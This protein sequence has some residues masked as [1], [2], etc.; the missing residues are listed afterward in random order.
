MSHA[1]TESRALVE[2]LE[3]IAPQGF[4]GRASETPIGAEEVQCAVE[5]VRDTLVA[6]AEAS[7]ATL[8]ERYA[9]LLAAA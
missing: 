3:H 9:A 7:A 2:A 5:A 1:V 6:L 4:R 8:S